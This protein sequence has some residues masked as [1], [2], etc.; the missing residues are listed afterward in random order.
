M[1]TCLAT[2]N[3]SPI[4]AFLTYCEPIESSNLR[5]INTSRKFDSPSGAN[6]NS[7]D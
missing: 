6:R 1:E 4:L 2:Y 5:A 7:C 3:K